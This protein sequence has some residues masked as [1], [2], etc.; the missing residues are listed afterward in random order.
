MMTNTKG[1]KDFGKQ[2]VRALARNGISFLGT[3]WLPGTDGSWSAIGDD[4]IDL[5]KLP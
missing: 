2:V 3:T 4:T 1:S 5:G